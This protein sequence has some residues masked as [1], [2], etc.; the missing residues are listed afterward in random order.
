VEYNINHL[1]LPVDQ[2]RYSELTSSEIVERQSINYMCIFNFL[3]HVKAAVKSLG[4]YYRGFSFT[5]Q[6]RKL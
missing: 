5:Y 6:K 4:R 3:L 1:A 2:T